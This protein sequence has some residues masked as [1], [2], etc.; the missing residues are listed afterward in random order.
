MDYHCR[1]SRHHSL[2]S[3]IN[4]KISPDPLLKIPAA[5]A[6]RLLVKESAVLGNSQSIRA[7]LIPTPCSE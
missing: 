3:T 4:I 2:N 7:N 5:L 1:A 6:Q